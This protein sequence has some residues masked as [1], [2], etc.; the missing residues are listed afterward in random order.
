[1]KVKNSAVWLSKEPLD[2]LM[3]LKLPIS[4]GYKLAR[5]AAKLNERRNAIDV[6]RNGLIKKYG[7]EKEGN[8][9]VKPESENWT[10]FVEDFNSLMALEEEMVI[11]VL[12]I[13][14][15]WDGKILEIE[16]EILMPLLDFVE[17]IDG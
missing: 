6:V 8:F 9:T 1:M 12:K 17:V 7:Q 5:L 2:N 15:K 4:T 13:P 3:A 10:K 11:E 16:S 14:S